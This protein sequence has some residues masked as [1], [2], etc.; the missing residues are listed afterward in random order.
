MAVSH[1]Q[2]WGTLYSSIE[3]QIWC[4]SFTYNVVNEGKK[5]YL[6]FIC[7]VL[8]LLLLALNS[9]PEGMV[10]AHDYVREEA[11][12]AQACRNSSE[13]KVFRML[14]EQSASLLSCC[15]SLELCSNC[16]VAWLPQEAPGIP[17]AQSQVSGSSLGTSSHGLH[18][19]MPGTGKAGS[20]EGT[21]R[22]QSAFI[23]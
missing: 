4:Y 9:A 19:Q 1:C 7:H 22:N 15:S 20:G 16:S 18:P 3:K 17:K 6:H 23:W 11:E 2:R 12:A 13:W 8:L 14:H 5:Q 10:A 21:G